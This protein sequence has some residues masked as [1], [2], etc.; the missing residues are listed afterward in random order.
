MIMRCTM[1][2]LVLLLCGPHGVSSQQPRQSAPLPSQPAAG[3]PESTRLLSEAEAVAELRAFL[4]GAA[5]EGR[6]SGAVLLARHGQPLFQQAYGLA[7][8]ERGIRNTVDTRFYLGS[9]NKMF[10]AVAVAQLV[11]QGRLAFNDPLA[12]FLP[13]F[14]D[15]EAAGR[16]RIE[17]LL[18]HTSGLGNIFSPRFM[19]ERPVTVPAMLELVRENSSLSFEPGTSRRYSNTGFLVLGAVIEKVTGQS[20]YEYVQQHIYRPAGMRDSGHELDA[21]VANLARGYAPARDGSG[22]QATDLPHGGPAGGG[23]STL[24]DLLRFAEAL[25]THS[26]LSPEM[27]RTVLSARP[28]LGQSTYGY[29]FAIR[30]PIVGHSGGNPGVYANLDVFLDSGYTSVVLINQDR[31]GPQPE[32][33]NKMRQLVRAVQPR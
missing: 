29:G 28:E 7:D 18:T 30:G 24:A 32:Y 12:R 17:H 9:M 15:P 20:Y 11:E 27:T 21:P 6:L 3:E 13:D 31:G 10:T 26:L 14:P 4:Q 2:A 1:L 22:L 5:D 19:Q 8:R 25:R 23:Y 16:I 33:E